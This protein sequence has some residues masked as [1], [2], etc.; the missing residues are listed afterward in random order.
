MP[1]MLL[2]IGQGLLAVGFTLTGGLKLI[3]RR[4]RLVAHMRWATT[5]PRWRIKLLGL[6]EVAG[7]VGLVVPWATGIAPVL[8]P[9]APRVRAA[10]RSLTPGYRCWYFRLCPIP[11]P[12]RSP[13]TL[14]PPTQRTP[15]AATR[16][17]WSSTLAPSTAS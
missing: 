5:W 8:T 14:P 2:W 9:I 7:A 16:P 15:R 3:A 4:E 11:L 17:S 13:W 12:R 6:A 1:N 10:A